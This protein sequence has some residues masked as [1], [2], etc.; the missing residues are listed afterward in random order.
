MKEYKSLIPEIELKYKTGDVRKFKIQSSRDAA[1]AFRHF[2]DPD[3]IEMSESV[4]VIFLNSA[5]NTIGWMRHSQGGINQSVIDIRMILGTALKCLATGIMICHN[6]PSGQ[7]R[8][9]NEDKEITRRL[10][11]GSKLFSITLL[12]HII[13]T[14]DSYY[15]FADEGLL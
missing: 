9:S 7:L 3:T 1:E 5:N 13:L 14:E 8:E 15:S 12:D 10:K 4:V 6:H 2:Y 11:E